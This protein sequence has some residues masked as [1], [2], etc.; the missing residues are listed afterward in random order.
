MACYGGKCRRERG[1]GRLGRGRVVGGSEEV[2]APRKRD[3]FLPPPP[4]LIIYPIG[5]KKHGQ[6]VCR[7]SLQC[8]LW[9]EFLSPNLRRALLLLQICLWIKRKQISPP[10]AFPDPTDSANRLTV[11]TRKLLQG[12]G[13]ARVSHEAMVAAREPTDHEA[14]CRS[15]VSMEFDRICLI[16]NVQ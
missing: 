6:V 11:S 5:R 12:V 4:L 3:S 9:G 8:K 13:I 15:A 14:L 16:N 2:C 7:P 1:G 10:V